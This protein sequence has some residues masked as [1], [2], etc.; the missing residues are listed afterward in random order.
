M[1]LKKL[2]EKKKILINEYKELKEDKKAE[3][4]IKL[5]SNDKKEWIKLGNKRNWEKSGEE[6][7]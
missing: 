3:E 4:I 5:K 6:D 1:K 7:K 2:Q